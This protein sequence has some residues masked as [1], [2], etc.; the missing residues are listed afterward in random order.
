MYDILF[1]Q[2]AT[3]EFIVSGSRGKIFLPLHATPYRINYKLGLELF[4]KWL[5]E[6]LPENKKRFSRLLSKKGDI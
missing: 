3:A 6:I 4:E 1:E 2:A 5:C